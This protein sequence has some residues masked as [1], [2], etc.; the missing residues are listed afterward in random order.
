ME[1][2]CPVLKERYEC[3]A[4]SG[5]CSEDALTRNQSSRIFQLMRIVVA[6]ERELLSLKLSKPLSEKKL[7]IHLDALINPS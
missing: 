5:A 7:K 1:S 4:A 2:L 6:Q 3:D